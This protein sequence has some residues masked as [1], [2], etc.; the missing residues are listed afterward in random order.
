MN[1]RS[2]VLEGAPLRYAPEN[3]L[4]VVFLFA[5]LARN[6]QLRIEQVRSGFPDCI[7]YQKVGGQEKKIR[8]EFEYRAS[9][10]KAHKH[11]TRGCDWIVCWEHDWPS[12]P[13][14]LNVVE[15]EKAFRFRFQGVDTA[16][17]KE[18]VSLPRRE[19]P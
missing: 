4:G 12:A 18:P 2:E 11:S 16:S 17:D 8:I 7:A 15:S 10:F 5:K 9:N 19:F 6:W 13:P 14:H 1:Q 3:E